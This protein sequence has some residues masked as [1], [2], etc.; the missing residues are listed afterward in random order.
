MAKK[1]GAPIRPMAAANGGRGKEL[2]R[3]ETG[4]PIPKVPRNR[5]ERRAKAAYERK[6]RTRIRADVEVTH[7]G[8][9]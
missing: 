3:E 8:T 2:P 4:N 9:R 1:P 7:G 5:R 6:H